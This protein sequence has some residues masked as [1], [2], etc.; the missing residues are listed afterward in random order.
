SKSTPILDT[1]MRDGSR[2]NITFGHDISP[3]GSSFSIRRQ[4][5]V[6]LTP[7]DLIA[8]G[9]FSSEVMAH[10]WLYMEN[11][12]NILM[13]G[14]TATGKTSALNAICMFIPSST[15]IVTL[16]DTREVQLPH[17]NWIPTVTRESF[18]RDEVGSIELEALL[19]SSLRQRP[20]Y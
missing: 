1:T 7:L 6:P 14:G 10:F 8:W 3:K 16:E 18:N 15:R 12:K 20:D 5:K 13:C 2:I 19:K 11:G 4:K 9:T 17:V